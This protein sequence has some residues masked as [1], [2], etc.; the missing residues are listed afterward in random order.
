MICYNRNESEK[1]GWFCMKIKDQ[2]R[3]QKDTR[4]YQ[5]TK[6]YL[7]RKKETDIEEKMKV[8]E[9]ILELK[10]LE[11]RYSYLYDLICDYLDYEF[12]EKNICGFDCGLCKRRKDMIA[13]NIQKDTYENGCCHG[14]LKG[15]TCEHLEPGK[16]CKIKNIGCKTFT[17][18]YLRKQGY[19]YHVKDIYFA[20]YF[21]NPRQLF[22]MENTFFVDKPIILEGIMKRR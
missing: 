15:K 17:C 9:K 16:G 7:E 11:K 19:R 6:K 10:E 21:F 1:L 8:V 2:I 5:K 20:R 4:I 22:Y 3:N 12:K 14:Y 18:F 13:R